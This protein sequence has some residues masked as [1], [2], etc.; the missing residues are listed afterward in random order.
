MLMSDRKHIQSDSYA[1]ENGHLVTD[2]SAFF[3]GDYIGS[4][5]TQRAAQQL[6]DAY[7]HTGLQRGTIRTCEQLANELTAWETAQAQYD[8]Q[9]AIGREYLRTLG[10]RMAEYEAAQAAAA[11]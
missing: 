7:V 11:A 4:R 10:T 8:E 2:Y 9:A 6:L 3:D 1:D 5:P